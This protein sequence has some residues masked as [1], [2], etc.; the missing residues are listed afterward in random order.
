MGRT[1][2]IGLAVPQVDSPYFAQLAARIITQ[3]ESAGY[4]VAIE[5]QQR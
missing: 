4:H 2:T 1:G 3:A 5:G